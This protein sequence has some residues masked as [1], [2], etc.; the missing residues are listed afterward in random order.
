MKILQRVAGSFLVAAFGVAVHGQGTIATLSNNNGATIYPLLDEFGAPIVTAQPN[1]KIE[2]FTYVPGGFPGE[3]PGFGIQ[4]GSATSIGAK[5]RFNAGANAVVPGA[6]PG[7]RVQLIVRSWDAT[8]A[9]SYDGAMLKGY[10][11]PFWS[12]VLGGDPDGDGPLLPITGK[13][14]ANG[15]ADG[16]QPF[17]V[18]VAIPEPSTAGL[19]CLGL[20]GL[21]A[22]GWV[23]RRTV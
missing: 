4:L 7:T 20:A 6:A 15:G 9:S 13:T 21:V 10:S 5:G 23:R 19:A 3:S 2:V 1:I 11:A 12:D 14:L 18:W 16:F 22:A 17:R 8:T